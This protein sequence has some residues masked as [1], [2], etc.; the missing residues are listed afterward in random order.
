MYKITW[1]KETGGV[2]LNM[3]MTN[4][5]LGVSPRPV[6]YE[7]LD[8]LGMDKLGWSYPH[9]KE[10]LIWA[11]NK[12]Y[13]YRGNPCFSVKGANIY[14]TPTVELREGIGNDMTLQ[15]VDVARMIEKNN[16]PMFLLESEAIEFIRDTYL[17]YSR[18]KKNPETAVDYEALALRAEKKTKRKMAIV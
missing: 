3:K 8:M 4:D 17:T 1:D 9:C 11:I 14:D 5:A 10:P 13:F 6:F 18:T 7:E 15:P 16:E 12:Q 2:M